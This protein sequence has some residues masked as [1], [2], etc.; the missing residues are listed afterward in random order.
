MPVHIDELIIKSTVEPL[1]DDGSQ[2]PEQRTIRLCNEDKK[3][4]LQACRLMI[5]EILQEREER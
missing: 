2:P 5:M 1:P 3:E 4:I